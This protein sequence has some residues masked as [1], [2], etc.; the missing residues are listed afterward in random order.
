MGDAQ[1]AGNARAH[2]RDDDD[3][4]QHQ[5]DVDAGILG[6][7][8]VAAHHVHV[9][10]EA[11][12]GQHQMAGQQ[13]RRRHQ[14]QAGDA[15]HPARSQE[16]NEVRHG[17]GDLAADQQRADAGADLHHC[18]SHDERRD[19]DQRDAGRVD[20]AQ[21]E[22]A[23]QRQDDGGEAWQRHIGDVHVAFLQREICDGDARDIGDGRDRKVYLGAQ[24]DEGE[25]DGNDP[26]HRDLGQDV[27]GI[28]QRGKRPARQGEED[29]QHD[30]GRERR[31][32]PHLVAQEHSHRRHVTPPP[33]AGPC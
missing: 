28:V 10:A 27:R 14:H 5:L 12:V 25:A 3:G 29:H 7:L 15:G 22:A 13:E 8:A 32:D 20:Q 9:A 21:H 6:R 17:I 31:D 24:D 16:G 23:D 30:Q 26:R 11:R 19:T 2:G 4:A 33:E 1:H 18:E